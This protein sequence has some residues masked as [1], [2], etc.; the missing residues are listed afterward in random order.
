MDQE[1]DV[2]FFGVEAGKPRPLAAPIT[3]TLALSHQGR[4]DAT[5]QPPRA[6]PARVTSFARAP[7]D[8]RKG[9]VVFRLA[10]VLPLAPS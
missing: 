10:A 5:A 2:A 8:S 6:Y 4:G 7:F 1:V 3:L 9:R